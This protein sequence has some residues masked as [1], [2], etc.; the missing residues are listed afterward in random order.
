MPLHKKIP[1][2]VRAT[3]ALLLLL[4]P[5][6]AHGQE[7]VLPVVPHPQEVAPMAGRFV[8]DP[9]ATT[10]R[11]AASDT[12]G[13]TLPVRELQ[14]T[15]RLLFDR[16]PALNAD[17]RQ[18]V[19]L[20]VPGEDDAFRERCREH[21]LWP[22][23]RLGDEG[24]VLLIL[25]DEILVAANTRVGLYYGTQTLK[26]LLRAA[27]EEHALAA[28]KVT[29]WPDLRY[30]GVMDDI[31][32]GPVPTPA[33][34]RQQVRRLAEMKINMLMYYTE[35]VVR[36]ERHGGFA[37][38]GGALSIA[39]WKDLADYAR[40]YHIQLV[41]SFQSF[42]HFE[43]ILAHPAYRPLGESDRLLSPVL[44]ESI[45]LLRDVYT[46]MVPAFGAP[47]FNVNSDETF[48][49]G[50]GASKQR[51]D[52]LGKGI[53]YAE[54]IMRMRNVLRGLGVRTMMWGDVALQHPEV[55]ERLPRDIIMLTWNYDALDTFAPLIVPFQQ[56]GFDVMVVP[57]VLNSNRIMPDF[58]QTTAN[59]RQFV[60][61]GVRLGVMGMLNTV[62]DDGGTALFARDWYGVA[63]SADQSW[64]ASS[65][66]NL[67]FDRR[68]DAGL[69]GDLHG[70]LTRAIHH[71][72]ALGDLE[73]TDAMNERVLW[74]TF[75]PERGLRLR[76]S[77]TDWTHVLAISHDAEQALDADPLVYGSDLDYFRFTAA[78]YRHLAERRL[79]LSEAAEA[80]RE[81]SLLQREAP[82]TARA[83]L[84]DVLDRLGQTRH[85]LM[86]RSDDFRT[87]WLR[88]NRS[89][90]LDLVLDRF[91]AQHDALADT[92]RR[93]MQALSDFD[94]GHFLP[95][96]TEVRLAIEASAGGYFRE[97][98][99]SGPLPNPE[100]ADGATADYLAAMGGEPNARPGVAVEWQYE[101]QTYRWRRLASPLH[102]EV[103]LAATYPD[104]NR[105]VALY[106]F[107][108]IDS[109]TAR[110]VRATFGSNDGITVFLNGA[111]VFDKQARQNLMIDDDEA[112]LPLNAGRNHLMLKISQGSGGW[113]FSFRLPDE[114][115][116]SQKNRYRI[117]DE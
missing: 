92:E 75:L 87:L 23:D 10:I 73:P 34:L 49:L 102:A 112:W 95:P 48:D 98:L 45:D 89:Y 50:R 115:V 69:Y 96:P 24:Y 40:R 105:H 62:W 114:T 77:L 59:I 33:F 66:D 70:G 47:F 42:G 90:A 104:N 38:A 15:F 41:G 44:D 108:T 52:S 58:R 12:T 53:V 80:Y 93:V 28:V 6:S 3:F 78:L 7:I 27:R 46:E 9:E 36:T 74:S 97:W 14:A 2:A 8:L 65:N 86:A 68:F 107:A 99:V 31:S 19:W 25:P 54:H 29:D 83:L 56:A 94:K 18:T 91:N 26:Q 35:H 17:T 61:D 21:G 43:K 30:R 22:D 60:A 1:E 32:R 101:G 63:F 109:P 51:V 85:T 4:A 5:A 16:A 13:L 37:P 106:A 64:Q 67:D 100:G 79:A 72:N 110:R 103:D 71:L 55:L 116:R 117:L 57:G 111:V 11:L 76:L 82:R 88:E 113:G 84:V 39:E 20:G 81:A